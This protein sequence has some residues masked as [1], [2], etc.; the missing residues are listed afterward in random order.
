MSAAAG[1]VAAAPAGVK[2][3]IDFSKYT[4]FFTGLGL[5][6]DE[7][8]DAI[9]SGKLSEDPGAAL[10][11]TTAEGEKS[12]KRLAIDLATF[13]SEIS[14]LVHSGVCSLNVRPGYIVG[15]GG[16]FDTNPIRVLVYGPP[17]PSMRLTREMRADLE[18]TGVLP[19]AFL[20]GREQSE[21]GRRGIY[22]DVICSYK[23]SQIGTRFLQ[24]FHRI[25]ALLGYDYIKLSSLANVVT[26]YPRPELGYRFRLECSPRAGAQGFGQEILTDETKGHRLATRFRVGKKPMWPSD[27]VEAVGDDDYRTFL[28]FLHRHGLTTKTTGGCSDSSLSM[29]DFVRRGCAEDGFHMAKCD[30]SAERARPLA[31]GHRTRRNRSRHGRTRRNSRNQK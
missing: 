26:Y 20:I 30:L 31:G 6:P 13:K 21:G 29:D 18:A 2:G 1:P 24:Y 23:E 3:G 19:I 27:T 11:T 9:L 28:H 16:I 17:T 5:V 7:D 10:I 8:K 12:N 4:V 15:K 25:V 14:K 22:I